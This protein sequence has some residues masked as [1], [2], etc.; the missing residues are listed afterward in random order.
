MPVMIKLGTSEFLLRI[1]DSEVATRAEE[2]Q[3]INGHERE[4]GRFL[5]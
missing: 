4:E 3:N 1:R 5:H 2:I